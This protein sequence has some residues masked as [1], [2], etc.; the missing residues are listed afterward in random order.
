MTKT[1]ATKLADIRANPSTSRAFILADAKDADM[2]WGIASA[3]MPHPEP[4]DVIP[5]RECRSMND[6]VA[7]IRKIVD[8]GLV[9]IMLASV[10]TMA[11]LAHE[12][13]IFEQSGVTPAVRINDTTDVWCGRG[14]R[15][16]EAPSKPFATA[17]IEEAQFGSLTKRESKPCVNLGL[18]SITFNNHTEAD[19]CSL[20]AFREFRAAAER[21]GFQYFLE[22]FAPNMQATMTGLVGD[23]IPAFVNDCLVRMLAAIPPS[24]RPLF[25]KIPYFGPRW[26]EELV[27]YDPTL[28]VGILGG[29]SGTTY[30]AFKLLAEAQKHGA[31]AALFGRK[32]KDAEDPLAFVSMLHRIAAVQITPEEAVAAYHADLKKKGVPCKR[33][34][35]DDCLLTCSELSYARR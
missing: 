9:D 3:G 12:E 17:Y 32:I 26:I 23:D 7:D 25:L 14:A 13:R 1:L 4:G 15:Y 2:A 22:V 5:G 11:R 6:L 21:A 19:H 27:N 20:T 16:R 18:Y 8:Q 24:G 34:I 35:E 28:V 29:S 33:S 31:R 10:S 30:D